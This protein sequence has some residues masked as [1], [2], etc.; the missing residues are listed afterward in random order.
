MKILNKSAKSKLGKVAI[1]TFLLVT[2]LATKVIYNNNM[3]VVEALT[4]QSQSIIV[5]KS[6]TQ[7][8]NNNHIIKPP[9]ITRECHIIPTIPTVKANQH[10]SFMRCTQV[11]YNNST[12]QYNLQL[13]DQNSEL[14]NYSICKSQLNKSFLQDINELFYNQILIATVDNNTNTIQEFNLL[15][16]ALTGEQFSPDSINDEIN[17]LM[18]KNHVKDQTNMDLWQ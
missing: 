4:K 3:Q 9:H 13:Q 7:Q 8:N 11:M 15:D 17:R 2:V 5:T 1:S 18:Y 6:T 10:I 14:F 16:E 12:Q